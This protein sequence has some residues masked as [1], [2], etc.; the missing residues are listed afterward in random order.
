MGKQTS[1]DHCC[2]SSLSVT[3][4]KC[5]FTDAKLTV[6]EYAQKGTSNTRAK[7]STVVYMQNGEYAVNQN[8]PYYTQMQVQMLWCDVQLCYLVIFTKSG[9]DNLRYFKVRR[10]ESFCN[11]IIEK[12]VRFLQD[13]SV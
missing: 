5:P 13:C 2:K 8:H 1:S 3:E 6:Q 12:A 4:I 7:H 11:N 10:D 9:A